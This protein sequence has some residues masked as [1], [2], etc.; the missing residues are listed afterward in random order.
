MAKFGNCDY[1][2]FLYVILNLHFKCEQLLQVYNKIAGLLHI[3]CIKESLSCLIFN[4]VSHSRKAHYA[5]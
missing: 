5:L 2:D 4:S 1:P 3:K